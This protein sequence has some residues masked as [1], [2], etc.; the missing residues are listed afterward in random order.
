MASRGISIATILQILISLSSKK[1][2][3]LHGCRQKRARPVT[4]TGQEKRAPFSRT[5][6]SVIVIPSRILFERQMT[7]TKD[8]AMMCICAF[9]WIYTCQVSYWLLCSYPSRMALVNLLI[10]VLDGRHSLLQ[11]SDHPT[12]IYPSGITLCC[13]KFREVRIVN[14]VIPVERG[15]RDVQAQFNRILVK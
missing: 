8:P 12:T 3:T 9:S 11:S 2:E 6:I 13:K 10:V 5:Y 7:S 14:K 4:F 15:P 1:P